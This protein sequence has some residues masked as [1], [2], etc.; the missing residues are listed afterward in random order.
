MLAVDDFHLETADLATVKKALLR[1]HR[2]AAPARRRGGGGRDER[3]PGRPPAVHHRPRR[4]AA[5]RRAAARPEPLLP[6]RVR[7]SAHHATT[8]RSSSTPATW[9][10]WTWPC[11]S[12]STSEPA[13]RKDENA[14]DAGR[15]ADQGAWPARSSPRPP[16][17]TSQ[18]LA[19]LERLVRGLTPLRGRK[20]VALFSGGFFLGSDRQS[21][22]RDLEVIADAAMRAGVV[23]YAVDARGLVAT[24]AIGDA[25]VGRKLRH[26]DQPR[27]ARAHRAA[28]DG[29]GARRQ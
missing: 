20:V 24:P 23:V 18:T 22:R 28:S 3:E 15:A 14:P 4:P 8:R 29:G 6:R 9:K 2:R 10:P 27:R 21:S 19:S 25:S 5:R 7:S 11:R 12:S 26:H 13:G 17:L 16:T 1:L